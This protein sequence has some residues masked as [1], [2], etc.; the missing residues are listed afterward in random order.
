MLPLSGRSRKL[1]QRNNVVFPLPEEPIIAI[2]S[3]FSRE[4]SMFRKTSKLPK[5]FSILLTSKIATRI[6]P[7]MHGNNSV[8]FLT[9]QVVRLKL[10]QR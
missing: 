7:F 4:K 6:P 5:C 8:S 9:N 2:D 10:L 1:R 3:P